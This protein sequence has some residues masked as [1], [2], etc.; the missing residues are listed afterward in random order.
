MR[1]IRQPPSQAD[2]DRIEMP[3]FEAR[4]LGFPA[5][6]RLANTAYP[7]QFYPSP[8][9][10]LT[11]ISR[12]YPC[13]YLAED[14]GTAVA[15]LWGDQFYA[16]RAL[17][18][19]IFSIAR[20]EAEQIRFLKTESN[21]A[22]RLC[23]LTDGD[24]RLRVGIDSSTLYCPDLKVPQGWAEVIA[25]HPANLD[26]IL[27]RSRHTDRPCVV[28]WNR[29]DRVLEREFAFTDAGPF[30]E[31]PESYAIA[32]KVGVTLSFTY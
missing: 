15:E 31:S 10:R 26:G 2:F 11:P 12:A 18:P 22:L 8:R 13:V 6:F 1:E 17:G 30:I 23:D 3:A 20:S 28:A 29:L 27:Y 5:W 9:S 16:Q 32:K 19:A 4:K 25:R 21:P 24:T 7:G 14:T